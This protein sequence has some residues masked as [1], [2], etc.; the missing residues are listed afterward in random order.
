LADSSSVCTKIVQG[1]LDLELSL[2]SVFLAGNIEIPFKLVSVLGPGR[3]LDQRVNLCCVLPNPDGDARRVHG[4]LSWFRQRRP[5]VQR[6]ESIVF[7]CT[8]VL[9]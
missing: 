9:A 5:Y 4:G 3:A 6:G 2:A 7:P 8:E 1:I